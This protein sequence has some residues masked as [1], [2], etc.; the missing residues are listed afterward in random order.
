MHAERCVQKQSTQIKDNSSHLR[1]FNIGV[2]TRLRWVFHAISTVCRFVPHLSLSRYPAGLVSCRLVCVCCA[3]ALPQPFLPSHRAWH[4]RGI[5]NN[6]KSIF[7]WG[8]FCPALD[9]RFSGLE[10]LILSST[11]VHTFLVRFIY[12]CYIAYQFNFTPL[13]LSV[14]YLVMG[15]QMDS[16]Y[17]L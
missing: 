11:R 10:R 16:I 13:F 12:P 9:G 14:L 3:R 5:T 4:Q 1:C 2:T 17:R 8:E 15:K 6:A 7:K